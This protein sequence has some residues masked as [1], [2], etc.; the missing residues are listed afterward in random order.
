VRENKAAAI[1]I[2]KQMI[3]SSKQMID[4]LKQ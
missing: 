3:D 4:K 2:A 1:K